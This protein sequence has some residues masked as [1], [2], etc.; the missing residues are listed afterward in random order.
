MM[1]LQKKDIRIAK[2]D[3]Q[4][5]AYESCSGPPSLY[6]LRQ[7][8]CM[9]YIYYMYHLHYKASSCFYPRSPHKCIPSICSVFPIQLCIFMKSTSQAKQLF[10]PTPTNIITIEVHSVKS[11][12]SLFTCPL[13]TRWAQVCGLYSCNR[14]QSFESLFT[15][16]QTVWKDLLM[17]TYYST[18]MSNIFELVP[19][20]Y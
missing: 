1:K 6:F 5:S 8:L 12:Y 9:E 16:S 14:H 3:F 2:K 13:Y 7:L 15:S 4:D 11:K 20:D 17:D 19:I 18:N 10:Q